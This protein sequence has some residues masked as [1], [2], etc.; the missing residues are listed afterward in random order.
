MKIVILRRL[1]QL[2]ILSLFVLGN[3]YGVKILLGDFSAST[4][5]GVHLADPFAVIQLLLA[6]FSLGAN[7]IF[8]AFI[9]AI[10]YALIAPRAFCGW[11]CPV[12]FLSELAFNLRAKFGSTNQ[13]RV[14]NLSKNARYYLLAFSLIFSA[15]FGFAAFESVS[16]VGLLV[17]SI[18]FLQGSFFG[19]VL[20]I[21]VFEIFIFSRGICS[22]ICPLGAFYAI[23]SKFSLIRISHNFQNCTK[24]NKCK[25]VCP[26]NQVL[27]MIAKRNDFVRNSECISCGRCI[28]VCDDDALNFNIIRRKQ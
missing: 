11:V 2:T 7:A 27:D 19:I 23:I 15:I 22:H 17:R 8:G 25:V 4:L 12:N 26:E 20:C 16:Q 3:F 24:C 9:V 21:L 5:F 13:K 6:G 28:D 10:F 18:V 1:T 14:L